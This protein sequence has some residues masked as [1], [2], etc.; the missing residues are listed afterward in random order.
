[1]HSGGAIVRAIATP[2]DRI[3]IHRACSRVGTILSRPHPLPF[4]ARMLSPFGIRLSR[5]VVRWSLLPLHVC[6]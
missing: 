4:A 2:L 3:L 6:P 5:Y 1:M